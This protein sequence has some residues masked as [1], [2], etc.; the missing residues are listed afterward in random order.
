MI[1]I[2]LTATGRPQYLTY[3]SALVE[4]IRKNIP[5][6]GVVLFKSVPDFFHHLDQQFQIEDLGWPRGSMMRYH[7]FLRHRENLQKYSHLFCMDVD[8]LVKG[9]I[10]PGEICGI[11][12]TAVLHPGFVG[13]PVK[14]YCRDN[15]STAFIQGNKEYYQGCF[16]GGS[17]DAYLQMA[18]NIAQDINID[19]MNGVIPE[20]FDEAHLNRYLFDHSP[21]ITLPPTFAY[22]EID[23]SYPCVQG[24]TPRII[25]LQKHGQEE[26]K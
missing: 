16:Q 22:P 23:E 25:H 13:Q 7:T 15:R 17:R 8:M 14:A 4:S 6:S 1:G 21:V 9:P 5:N 19:D 2:L 18:A 26:W 24:Q 20:W 10:D 11:G 3:I 12:L